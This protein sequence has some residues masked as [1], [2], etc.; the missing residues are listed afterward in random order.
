MAFVTDYI[1]NPDHYTMQFA[2]EALL[3]PLF[4]QFTCACQC[5][6]CKYFYKSIQVPVTINLL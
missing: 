4:I 3:R 5:F 1:F 6:F 2:V